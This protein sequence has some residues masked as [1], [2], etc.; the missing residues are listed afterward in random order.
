MEWD[1]I[2]VKSNTFTNANKNRIIARI[3]SAAIDGLLSIFL[4]ILEYCISRLVKIFRR[5]VYKTS[6]VC[7]KDKYL[8]GSNSKI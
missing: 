1:L 8:A 6:P 2:F 3:N 7:R 4:I 5:H